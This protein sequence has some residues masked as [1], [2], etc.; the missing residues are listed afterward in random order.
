MIDVKSQGDKLRELIRRSGLKI[1]D[2]DIIE[3]VIYYEMKLRKGKQPTTYEQE[4][5]GALNIVSRCIEVFERKLINDSEITALDNAK[6]LLKLCN[7]S[8]PLIRLLD[9]LLLCTSRLR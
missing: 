3:G 2:G 9:A 6:K 7:N 5:S 1:N 8:E 4:L